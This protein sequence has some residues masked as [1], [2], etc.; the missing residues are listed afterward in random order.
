[1]FLPALIIWAGKKYLTIPR[2]GLV[3]FGANR[4]SRKRQLLV[5]MIIMV[6]ITIGLLILTILKVISWSNG[7]GYY[8][9]SFGIGLIIA[10]KLCII[11]YFMEYGR[12]YIYGILMGAAIPAAKV[13]NRYTGEPIDALIAFGLPAAVIIIIGTIMLLKFLAN[14]PRPI[15]SQYS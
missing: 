2:L 10:V 12:M 15:T 7:F 3:K 11:A 8:S 9:M 5:A 1:M 6:A 4:Q 14:Y 13:L